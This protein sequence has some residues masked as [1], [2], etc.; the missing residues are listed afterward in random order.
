[1]LK[2]CFGLAAGIA[3]LASPALAANAV[4]DEVLTLCAA[5]RGDARAVFAAADT[6]GWSMR[7]DCVLPRTDDANLG[8]VLE[9]FDMTPCN[10]W[11]LKSDGESHLKLRV[12]QQSA[13]WPGGPYRLRI[14]SV[15]DD[16]TGSPDLEGAI[17]AALGVPPQPSKGPLI[18]WAW[19]E[20][21][22]GRAFLPPI[23]S[24]TD[25]VAAVDRGPLHS[26]QIDRT[27]PSPTVIYTEIARTG[28]P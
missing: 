20:T 15:A 14:C 4:L 3:L 8:E 6:A 17:A 13:D 28:A 25:L 5:H 18:T 1:M 21:P 16:G 10:L 19:S 12:V 24:D 27:A 11:R 26:L 23:T 2:R 9:M 22:S 7:P